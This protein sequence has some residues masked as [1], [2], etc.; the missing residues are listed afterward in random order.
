MTP[1]ARKFDGRH[2]VRLVE[3]MKHV[4]LSASIL[5]LLAGCY[6]PSEHVEGTF[7]PTE[8]GEAS[9]N[10]SEEMR[11]RPCELAEGALRLEVEV[12]EGFALLASP[13]ACIL[14]D[15]RAEDARLI[16]LT[17]IPLASETPTDA[18]LL[19][20]P[21]GVRRWAMEIGLLGD[22]AE[23]RDEG[24]LRLGDEELDFFVARGTPPDFEILRDVLLA[25]QVVENEQLIIM[26]LIP[27]DDAEARAELLA[28]LSGLRV[29]GGAP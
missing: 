29:D 24:R 2:E 23:A 19:E 21:D 15:E 13:E 5:C 3:I 20:E 25:R 26:V 12:P 10:S 4:V 1:R 17:S 14:V 7:T 22:D 27:P 18:L 16:T 9:S 28:A 11:M 8:G 6:S